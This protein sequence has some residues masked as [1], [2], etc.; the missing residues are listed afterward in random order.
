MSNDN[1]ELKCQST[2]SDKLINDTLV[3][4][5]QSSMPI[6]QKLSS[7]SIVMKLIIGVLLSMFTILFIYYGTKY[8]IKNTTHPYRQT[9]GKRVRFNLK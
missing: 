9:G 1:Y 5:N 3:P 2:D 7:N 6:K 8:V 4:L